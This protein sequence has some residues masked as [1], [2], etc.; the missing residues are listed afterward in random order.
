[1]E[2]ANG[3]S[4]AGEELT[5][6][7]KSDL[8]NTIFGSLRAEYFREEVYDLFTRPT[9]FPQL[10]T[11]RPCL[12]VGGR[13]TGKTTVLKCLSYEGQAHLKAKT[14]IEDWAYVGLYWRI[15]TSIV[16]A[17][18]GPEITEEQWIRVF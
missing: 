3:T 2:S 14:P 5:L 17:F 9:Y 11:V 12:L 8:L 15:D 1:M 16:R 7:E 13:G 18:D 4:V 10:Q 6:G